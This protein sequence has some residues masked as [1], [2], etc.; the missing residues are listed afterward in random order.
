[1]RSDNKTGRNAAH[2]EENEAGLRIEQCPA[3]SIQAKSTY[4]MENAIAR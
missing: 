4:P 3:S 2:G 1:M